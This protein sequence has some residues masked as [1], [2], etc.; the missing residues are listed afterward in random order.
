MRRLAL[1]FLGLGLVGCASYE[2]SYD[3]AAVHDEV[4]A[5]LRAF[6]AAERTLDPDAV[7]AFLDPEFS[8]FQDGV[9]ADYAATVEQIRA[10]LPKLR[11]FDARFDDIEIEV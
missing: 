9:R 1:A 7:I 8:M 11:S 4:L 10:S 6:E 5:T 3:A 2:S